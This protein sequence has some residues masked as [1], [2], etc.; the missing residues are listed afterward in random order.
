MY[1]DLGN[2]SLCVGEIHH[3]FIDSLASLIQ[4]LHWIH[5]CLN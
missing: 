5:Q 2:V 3:M 4:W 1:K